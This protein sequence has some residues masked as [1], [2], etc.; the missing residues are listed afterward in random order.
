MRR[1]MFTGFT[2]ALTIVFSAAHVSAPTAIYVSIAGRQ[3]ISIYHL[4]EVTGKLTYQQ[5]AVTDGEPGALTVDPERQVSR[6]GWP[7]VR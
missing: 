2:C 4:N 1:R 3:S 5:E 6:R 7:I